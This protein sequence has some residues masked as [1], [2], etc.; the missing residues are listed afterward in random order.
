MPEGFTVTV[1]GGR[2]LWIDDFEC[3]DCGKYF[4]ITLES[5]QSVPACE[6]CSGELQVV[7]TK[8][9]DWEFKVTKS[10]RRIIWDEKQIE[11]SHGKDWRETNKRRTEGGCGARQFYDGGRRGS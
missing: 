7:I 2:T 9:K 1:K 6:E 8:P 11:S 10:D 3:Q 4:E 5:G